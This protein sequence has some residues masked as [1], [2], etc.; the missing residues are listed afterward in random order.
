M[1]AHT[2]LSQL[3]CPLGMNNRFIGGYFMRFFYTASLISLITWALPYDVFSSEQ[4]ASDDTSKR[5][6]FTLR[7]GLDF[8]CVPLQQAPAA[9][10]AH[11]RDLGFANG[12]GRTLV[13]YLQHL[14]SKGANP[15]NVLKNH[16]LLKK[17]A[18]MAS[19]H[20]VPIAVTQRLADLFL[21]SLPAT[22]I[23]EV[24]FSDENAFIK[25]FDP[26]SLKK[27]QENVNKDLLDT[28]SKYI[29]LGIKILGENPNHLKQNL[30]LKLMAGYLAEELGHNPE[31]IA[32]LQ[33]LLP[34]TSLGIIAS[35]LD[36]VPFLIQDQHHHQRALDFSSAD[37]DLRLVLTQTNQT[38][39]SY[40]RIL[41][42][43]G[44][45]S[46]KLIFFA[47]A[48]HVSPMEVVA[49]LKDV[50]PQEYTDKAKEAFVWAILSQGNH[51][52]AYERAEHILKEMAQNASTDI[53][54]FGDV[55]Q[56]DLAAMAF[57]TSGQIAER[58]IAMVYQQ[59][60][61]KE[62]YHTAAHFLRT[63]LSSEQLADLY[64]SQTQAYIWSATHVGPAEGKRHFLHKA[65]QMLGF[66]PAVLVEGT[67][68]DFNKKNAFDAKYRELLDKIT[69]ALSPE[70]TLID[71]PISDFSFG[72]TINYNRALPW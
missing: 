12:A 32:H 71:R 14:S 24:G 23:N 27:L 64:L 55:M 49:A 35:I 22:L 26:E 7:S 60:D 42:P 63:I 48:I 45:V 17:H 53:Q 21:L 61:N 3:L 43:Y 1:H 40:E 16:A 2:L 5:P 18:Y 39:A 30:G 62:R 41:A 34:T 69:G 46:E 29:R 4:R 38:L 6:G 28:S 58:F 11:E 15:H 37:D 59:C 9:L 66:V 57:S 67:F 68:E 19:R 51:R 65:S 10:D 52:G 47:A 8:A 31:M 70:V 54:V 36:E 20:H 72:G 33:T 50:A 44:Q 13:T 25:S 56:H